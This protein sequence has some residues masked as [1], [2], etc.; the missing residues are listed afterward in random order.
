MRKQTTAPEWAPEED[1]YLGV[2]ALA[3][4][5]FAGCVSE[6]VIWRWART[7]II[8]CV[9]TGKTRGMVFHVGSVKAALRERETRAAQ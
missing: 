7:G 1:V 5:V 4:H 2:H 8:P 6:D 3:E 9:R